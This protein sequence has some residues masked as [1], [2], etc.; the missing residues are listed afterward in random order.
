MA[1]PGDGHD[2]AAFG[3]PPAFGDRHGDAVDLELPAAVGADHALTDT[4]LGRI[5]RPEF[6]FLDRR[7]DVPDAA[8]VVDRRVEQAR[9]IAPGPVHQNVEPQVLIIAECSAPAAIGK[10]QRRPAARPVITAVLTGRG[11]DI[12]I[13]D[14][15]VAGVVEAEWVRRVASY[16]FYVIT[17]H[18]INILHPNK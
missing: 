9:H 12:H 2:S 17:K 1:E 6:S 11:V 15:D 3:D 13:R 5:I 16:E 4:E 18:I 8:V 10:A 14:G 7:G